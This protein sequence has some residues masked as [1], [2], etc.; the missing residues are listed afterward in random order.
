MAV[1][2]MQTKLM[3]ATSVMATKCGRLLG[4]YNFFVDSD[5]KMRFNLAKKLNIF[6]QLINNHPRLTVK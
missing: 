1:G 5:N 3:C 6:K 4:L 2:R